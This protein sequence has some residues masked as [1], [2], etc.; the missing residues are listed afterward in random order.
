MPSTPCIPLAGISVSS[1][2]CCRALLQPQQPLS[3]GS[4]RASWMEKARPRSVLVS[5]RHVLLLPNTNK[6]ARPA[7]QL[8]HTQSCF[9]K[10]P[11]PRQSSLHAYRPAGF[12]CYC[13]TLPSRSNTSMVLYSYQSH[14]PSCFLGCLGDQQQESDSQGSSKSTELSWVP[15]AS[16]PELPLATAG[17]AQSST[18][19]LG[20]AGN[21]AGGAKVFIETQFSFPPAWRSSQ[22]PMA[23]QVNHPGA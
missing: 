23:S 19:Q 18:R 20:A 21:G 12:W 3:G 5:D 22:E 17:G 14:L 6:A 8:C 4:P 13:K 1:L 2:P 10:D 15:V 7:A 16:A 9:S 11:Q